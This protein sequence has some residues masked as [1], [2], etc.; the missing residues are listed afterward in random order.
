V[1]PM[2]YMPDC[3]HA[4]LTLMDAEPSALA[5]HNSF[6]LAAMSF[7]VGELAAEIRK[8]I[9]GFVCDYAP[10]ERQRIADTWPRSID[11]SAARREWNWKP[12][13]D[14]ERMTVDMLEH[15]RA[16]QPDP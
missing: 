12:R 3:I 13:Y 4:A 11:D 15:L 1:L 14:I 5:H 10:D 9:P 6:N 2:I 16:R 7:S 8:H